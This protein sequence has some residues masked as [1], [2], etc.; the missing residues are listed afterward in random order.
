LK[1]KK[2]FGQHFLTNPSTAEKIVA[3][4]G[5]TSNKKV[6]E[7]GPGKGILTSF[8]INKSEQF[9]AI[10]IDPEAQEYLSKN[11]PK[12]E[13]ILNDFLK[14]NMRE[15]Y[16]SNFS[17]IGNFPYNISSQIVF[18]IIENHHLVEEWVGMFQLEMGQRLI[19]TVDDGKEYGILSALLPFY[20]KIEKVM[21][22]PPGAFS[23]PPKVNSIVLKATRVHHNW[24][25][26]PSL[27]KSVIKTAFGQRRK[28]IVNSLSGMVS[29]EILS[30]SEY[31]LLR[32]EK[33]APLQFEFLTAFIEKNHVD[34]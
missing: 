19:A 20:Y 24:Q 7:I 33:I 4:L 8:L 30:N 21:T 27:L 34:N 14:C 25:C 1:A 16:S 10:D 13:V 32:P 5:D 11:L 9:K 31:G 23:P 12:A 17:L 6:L 18:K 15:I 3:A 29:K 26:K 2:H 28:M 22:L